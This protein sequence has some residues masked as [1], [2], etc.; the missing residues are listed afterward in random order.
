MRDSEKT[1]VPFPD[2]AAV[3]AEAAEWITRL[4]SGELSATDY[5]SFQEW[6]SR[7]PHHRDAVQRLSAL[8]SEL[9]VLKQYARPIEALPEQHAGRS[10]F[11]AL[12]KRSFIYAAAACLALAVVG[13]QFY[14]RQQTPS[15]M[16]VSYQT[17]VG[18]QKAVTLPDGSTVHMNTN[19]R[20]ELAYYSDRRDLKLVRGEAYFDVAHDPNRPF[21]VY[22]GH[23]LVRDIG[24]AFDVRLLASAVE[25]TVS[26]GSVEL[27]ALLHGGNSPNPKEER[28]GALAAGQDAVFGRKVE[29]LALVTN[30]A[31]NRKLAWRN[32]VLIYAGEPLAQ[33]VDDFNR[34]TNVKV[35]LADPRLQ[36][37]PVGGYFEIGKDEAFYE[38]L[39]N[40]FGLRV[41]RRDETHVAL[42]PPAEE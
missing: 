36:N 13:T 21:A 5:A 28:L 15:P 27:A 41:E 20:I 4:D 12:P 10:W 3:D 19:S 18:E 2:S 31:I 23:G 22:A 37:I 9:D 34:Y 7:S 1:V 26:R 30:A 40:N 42:L 24:T 38:A 35:A 32:G 6:Q 39:R 11:A 29:R 33:V 14:Q 25:V 16:V 8:W 17:T